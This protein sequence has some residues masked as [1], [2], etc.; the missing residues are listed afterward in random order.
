MTGVRQSPGPG[1]GAQRGTAARRRIS[2]VPSAKSLRAKVR[3]RSAWSQAG[4]RKPRHVVN[5]ALRADTSVLPL[6]LS[7]QSNRRLDPGGAERVSERLGDAEGEVGWRVAV[8]DEHQLPARSEARAGQPEEPR[9]P[10]PRPPR[11]QTMRPL[12]F[13]CLSVRPNQT[14]V[15]AC[16]RATSPVACPG[17]PSR[18]GNRPRSSPSRYPTAT[19]VAPQHDLAFDAEG[20]LAVRQEE[21]LVERRAG[22]WGGVRVPGASGGAARPGRRGWSRPGEPGAAPA[23]WASTP[24]GAEAIM[25]QTAA[26]VGP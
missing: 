3:D 12:R 23:R 10:G 18:T 15:P 11:G 7:G 4:A 5:L 9:P 13:T 19:R 8:D 22:R 24:R 2:S 25:A 26:S 6:A 21:G 14:V 1:G 17:L 16:H 20:R